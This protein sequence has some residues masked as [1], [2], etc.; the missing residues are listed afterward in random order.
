[1]RI[2]LA[3]VLAA[4]ALPARAGLFGRSKVVSRWTPVSISVN[5]DDAEW[6]DS[7]AFEED[8]LAVLAMNDADDLYLLITAHTREARDQLSGESRQDMTLWFVAPD[9]KTRDWGIRLPFSRRAPLTS[10]LRDPAGLDPEPELVQYRGAEVSSGTLPGDVIDR[11]A[12]VSRRPIWE[13][14]IPLKRL[15]VSSD[16]AV[17]TD[18]VLNAPASGAR[19]PQPARSREERERK[20]ASYHPEEAAWN[21]QSYSL[22]VRLA[23]DPSQP[24]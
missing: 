3:V 9:G 18:F 10:A 11:L 7:S 1:M 8:G 21:A 2:L 12:A 24:R 6:A 14:K 13:L 23:R 17:A 5:G 22:S 16:K 20:D 4:A 15:T 19:R